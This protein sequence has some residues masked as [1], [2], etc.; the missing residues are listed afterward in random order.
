MDGFIKIFHGKNAIGGTV[1][2][3]GLWMLKSWATAFRSDPALQIVPG[4]YDELCSAGVEFPNSAP[5]SGSAGAA[6]TSA[7]AVGGSATADGRA[8]FDSDAEMARAL[9]AQ[10]DR[11]D[12]A[13]AGHPAEAPPALPRAPV[14]PGHLPPG[15]QGGGAGGYGGAGYRHQPAGGPGLPPPPRVRI[16]Y[17][18]K[19]LSPGDQ[20]LCNREQLAKLRGDLSVVEQ[21]V[22]LLS[23]LL[24]AVPDG[25]TTMG[26]DELIPEIKGT[27]TKMQQRVLELCE[28]VANEDLIVELFAINDRINDAL[29][30]YTRKVVVAKPA[31]TAMAAPGA[32]QV[33]GSL[34]P[35]GGLVQSSNSADGLL[36]SMS[37]ALSSLGSV[38]IPTREAAAPSAAEA[39]G[40]ADSAPPAIIGAPMHT[41]LVEDA[42]PIVS[43]EAP[44]ADASRGTKKPAVVKSAGETYRL[45]SKQQEDMEKEHDDMFGL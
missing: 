42:R 2:E 41:P 7:S 18:V 5:G 22:S 25:Q 23:D 40:Q 4:A 44:S 30:L 3:R 34:P 31:P 6:A 8:S 19:P 15:F 37:S 36:G 20:V 35:P 24:G 1:R 12:R 32:G 10:F 11:E 21:N 27:C 28:H 29:A 9:A 33:T 17:R 13:A 14:G 16:E 39:G 45:Q 38:L 26:P 43:P